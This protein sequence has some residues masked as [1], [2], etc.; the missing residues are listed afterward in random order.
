MLAGRR[1]GTLLFTRYRLVCI[2]LRL[3]IGRFSRIAWLAPDHF[4]AADR[5]DDAFADAYVE[6]S[7]GLGEFREFID[8]QAVVFGDLDILLALLDRL[9]FAVQQLD[10]GLG[11]VVRLERGTSWRVARIAQFQR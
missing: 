7:Q 5:R 2:G 6:V 11:L 4:D 1:V 10:D 9:G 3:F 8:G